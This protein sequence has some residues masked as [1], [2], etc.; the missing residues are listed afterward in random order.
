[1]FGLSVPYFDASTETTK[2]RTFLDAMQQPVKPTFVN[3]AG[4]AAV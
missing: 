2:L 1:M 4:H 3:C